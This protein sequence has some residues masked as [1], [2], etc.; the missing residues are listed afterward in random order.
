MVTHERLQPGVDA[1]AVLDTCGLAPIMPMT[2][3]LAQTVGW[4]SAQLQTLLT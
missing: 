2:G 1:A 3:M 4:R